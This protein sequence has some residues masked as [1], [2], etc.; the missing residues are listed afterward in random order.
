MPIN[1]ALYAWCCLEQATWGKL[2]FF[3]G[4]SALLIG[5]RR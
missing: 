4:N 1:S 3:W 2:P 5:A